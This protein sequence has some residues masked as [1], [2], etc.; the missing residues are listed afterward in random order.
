M[1]RQA[2]ARLEVRQARLQDVDGIVDLVRRSYEDLPTYSPSEIRATPTERARQAGAPDLWIAT[3][4]PNDTIVPLHHSQRLYELAGF[5]KS[6]WVV[7]GVGHI[8]AIKERD[9]RKRLADFLARSLSPAH[10][11][12]AVTP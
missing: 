6:L 3:P 12:V 9:V 8:Q 5:P 10:G 2:K 7:P 4:I 1:T 11:P